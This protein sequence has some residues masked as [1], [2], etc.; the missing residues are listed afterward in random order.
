[1][2]NDTKTQ[3]ER[4]EKHL[5]PR[6]KMDTQWLEESSKH[7]AVVSVNT[8][9]PCRKLGA[10]KETMPGMGL[11]HLASWVGATGW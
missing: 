7:H 8:A 11:R 6:E 2:R 1:M 9:K 10:G 3:E 4:R 5:E